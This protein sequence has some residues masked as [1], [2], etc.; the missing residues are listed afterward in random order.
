M[1]PNIHY[2]ERLNFLPRLQYP[3][4]CPGGGAKGPAPLPRN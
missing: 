1:L 4:A 3:G 2:T